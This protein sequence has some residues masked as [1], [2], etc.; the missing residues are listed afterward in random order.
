M[1]AY[2]KLLFGLVTIFG[3]MI[4]GANRADVL[5]DEINLRNRVGEAA[6][7]TVYTVL[8]Q[9]A[10]YNLLLDCRD[11]LYPGGA[12]VFSYV[13]WAVPTN[14]GN[15]FRLG[16]IDFG[17]NFFKTKTPFNALYVTKETDSKTRTPA[18]PV[19]MQGSLERNEF[20]DGPAPTPG[21]SELGEP[22]P[23]P[24]ATP[25]PRSLGRIF[26]AGGVLAF[27]AIFGV[28]LVIFVI[29]RK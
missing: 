10:N 9:D 17:K 29:T 24:I 8:M 25:A 27:V 5:A 16:T 18:G 6:R 12:S 1:N 23:T 13:L 22:T 20:L 21:A 4:W 11:I 3:L 2:K 26:A 15:H 7:C 19:M 14:G 28:I